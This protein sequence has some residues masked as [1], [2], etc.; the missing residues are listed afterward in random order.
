MAYSR[1]KYTA[2]GSINEYS[3]PFPFLNLSS[4]EVRLNN[5]LKSLGA[6]YTVNQ[7]TAKVVLSSAPANGVEVDVRRKTPRGVSDRLVVF[8]DPSK[9]NAETLNRSDLQL[10]YIIQEALD[11]IAEGVGVGGGGGGS[12]GGGSPLDDP[13]LTD[14]LNGIIADHN[15]D[16]ANL[17]AEVTNRA[18]AILAEHNERVAALLAEAGN[19]NTAILAAKTELQTADSSLASQISV[20]NAKIDNP[21][22]GL[23]AAHARVTAEETARVTT[24]T[25]QANR[26]STLES[27]VN[28]SGSGILARISTIET[29]LT[30]GAD[31]TA[32]AFRVSNLESQVQTSGSGLLARVSTVEATTASHTSSLSSLTSSVSA[33]V[34]TAN[35]AN[36][37]ATSA[38]A[39]VTSEASARATADGNLS[40]QYVLRV[41]AGNRVAGMRITSASSPS[42]GDSSEI[43][44]DAA[45]FKVYNSGT[46][47]PVAPFSVVN[48]VVKMTNVEA[49]IVKAGTGQFA[50]T[51]VTG[52]IIKQGGFTTAQSGFATQ[53]IWSNGSQ[54]I[55]VFAPSDSYLGGTAYIAGNSG[56]GFQIRA[57]GYARFANLKLTDIACHP[58]DSERVNFVTGEDS[59]N[60]SAETNV[61]FALKLN[62][63]TVWVPFFNAV[64]A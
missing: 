27:Q 58:N 10:L 13:G 45:A 16:V 57:N 38:M 52:A 3:I 42:A 4:L 33:A 60:P 8:A 21:T 43:I 48:N 24:S 62:G 37:T 56:G 32:L 50:E 11:D 49:E 9:L 64:P 40:G 1:V 51:L 59:G 25:A 36:S 47:S 55:T 41:V 30:S 6:D 46:G 23:E 14:V 28:T 2:N 26:I 61:F 17:N 7:G 22:T 19:R 54:N 39:Q 15:T 35:G 31:N 34:T 5:V 63:R 53:T 18:A 29:T 20:V 12:G 44:F